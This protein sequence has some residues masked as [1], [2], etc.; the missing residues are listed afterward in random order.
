MRKTTLIVTLGWLLISVAR[1][2]S[3]PGAETSRAILLKARRILDVKTG[4]YIERAGILIEGDRIKEA[5]RLADVE[6]H[7]PERVSILDLGSATVLP[8]L[9]DC[10]T[11]L[12]ARI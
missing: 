12:L 3:G 7:L 4:L 6:D 2:Q 11:H 1:A 10:H 9:I 5:A 8:G